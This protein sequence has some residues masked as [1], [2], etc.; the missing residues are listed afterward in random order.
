MQTYYDVVQDVQGRAI[1]GASVYVRDS[2]NS[3]ATIYTPDGEPVVQ[4]ILTSDEGEFAFSA[5]NG[6]YTVEIVQG[7]AS[8][9]RHVSLFDPADSV[10]LQWA[11]E[12]ALIDPEPE[13]E[14]VDDL[15]GKTF[16]RYLEADYSVSFGSVDK[17]PFTGVVRNEI[18][19]ATSPWT[20]ITIPAALDGRRVRLRGNVRIT[21]PT[22][23]AY[24]AVACGILKNGEAATGNSVESGLGL[25]S[26]QI[27]CLPVSNGPD[28][29]I[30][31]SLNSAVIPVEE[32]DYFEMYIYCEVANITVKA[33]NFT[34]FELEVVG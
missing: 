32:G 16:M 6:S 31:F 7:G 20:Q 29:P 17:I 15:P 18:G 26:E 5:E 22:G 23:G 24:L 8:D 4:P 13:P 9:I 2:E 1:P 11:E 21:S 19:A 3:P 27:S 14:P 30:E 10:G 25:P 34:W 28:K 12:Q 33:C